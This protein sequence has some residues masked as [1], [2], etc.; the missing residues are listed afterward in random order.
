MATENN[1]TKQ[2]T[3]TRT[4]EVPNNLSWE[5]TGIVEDTVSFDC[6]YCNAKQSLHKGQLVETKTNPDK[7]PTRSG[8]VIHKGRT[9]TGNVVAFIIALVI[10]LIISG[11]SGKTG[12]GIAIICVVIFL[13]LRKILVPA[14]MDSLPIWIHECTNCKKKTYLAS[15]GN[16]ASIGKTQ[17]V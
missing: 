14:F 11:V 13:I 2:S 5:E 8:Q 16:N 4:I 15:D 3:G 17:S 1:T 6:A 7:G 12:T 9:V 10:G